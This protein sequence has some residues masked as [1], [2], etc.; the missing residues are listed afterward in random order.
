MFFLLFTFVYMVIVKTENRSSNNKTESLT[1]KL[2]NSNQ[3]STFPWVS[4]IRFWT[5]RAPELRF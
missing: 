5:P 2:Q 1:T 4:F 3:N